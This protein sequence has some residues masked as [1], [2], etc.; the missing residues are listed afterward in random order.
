MPRTSYRTIV[1]EIREWTTHLC[2]HYPSQAAYH[3]AHQCLGP[4][5]E[6][7][8]AV[9]HA[10][11]SVELELGVYLGSGQQYLGCPGVC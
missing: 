5:N 7:P 3:A 9:V 8:G 1:W 2:N 10:D 6:L 11:E 4:K